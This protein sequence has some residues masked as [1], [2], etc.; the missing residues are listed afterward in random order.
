MYLYFI[1]FLIVKNYG[2]YLFDKVY[3]PQYTNTNAI[4]GLKSIVNYV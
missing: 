1:L 4:E 2:N 3:N